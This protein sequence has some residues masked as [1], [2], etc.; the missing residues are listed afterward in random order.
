M[1]Y[2][3]E[4]GDDKTHHPEKFISLYIKKEKIWLIRKIKHL[5]VK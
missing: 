1:P 2:V 4:N 5:W 3:Q